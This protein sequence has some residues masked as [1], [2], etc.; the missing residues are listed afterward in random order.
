MMA[1]LFEDEEERPPELKLALPELGCLH[2][3]NQA[4]VPWDDVKRDVHQ[5]EG[6]E[7]EPR[8]A[9]KAAPKLFEKGEGLSKGVHQS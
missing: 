5:H 3:G 9:K 6:E 7:H 1:L 2:M 8:A 4:L